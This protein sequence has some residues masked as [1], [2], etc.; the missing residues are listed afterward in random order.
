MNRYRPKYHKI[1]RRI[2]RDVEFDANCKR[3]ELFENKEHTKSL[4]DK[5]TLCAKL[6]TK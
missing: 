5:Y 4:T 2:V 6:T 1:D 3:P